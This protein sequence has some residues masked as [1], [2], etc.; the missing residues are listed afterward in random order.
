[1]NFKTYGETHQSQASHFVNYV[2][3][4]VLIPAFGAEA[5]HDGGLSIY[6][7]LDL[8]LEQKA[9]QLLYHHLYET[10]T[11]QRYSVW[12]ND[13]GPLNRT[14]NMHN[15]AVVVMNPKNGEILVMNGSA[16][17]DPS[18]FTPAMQGYY[19]A[20]ISPRPTGSS[21]KPFVYATAFEMGWYPAMIV[22]DHQ[23]YYPNGNKPYVPQNADEHF[24]SGLGYPMTIRNALASSFN[25]P[26]IDAIE[27]AGI[28]NVVHMAGRLGL[29]EVTSNPA[30][31]GPAMA[32]G[33][34]PI[35]P[36]NMT[37][38]YGTFANNGL[39]VPPV[40]ILKIIDK[41]NK[42]IYQY[43]ESHP[44]AIQVMQPGV[45]FLINSILADK[46]A[47]YHEFAPSNP[48][49]MD[50]P[51]AVKTGTTDRYRD[52]W[53]IGYTPDL[54]TGVWVGNSNNDPMYTVLGVTGAAPVWNELMTYA[55]EHYHIPPADFVVP[56]D[57]H[58]AQVSA[59]TGLA[60]QAGQ[61][62]VSDWFVDGST[63]T[64]K[65]AEA[66][67]PGATPTPTPS[68]TPNDQDKQ[69]PP[70]GKSGHHHRPKKA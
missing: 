21:F 28:N 61:P 65:G 2:V 43:D 56:P 24:H 38:A 23:T 67:P 66:P 1:M 46:R 17:T 19:N 14:K 7:T 41:Q 29:S 22:N 47:R 6:T 68:P 42:V 11:T 20:A 36:L 60:P 37:D 13:R 39:R 62:T 9:E 59:L 53:T 34:I 57:V 18:M 31:W 52:N 32:I 12:Y 49:E 30:N 25:I 16:S 5:L 33:S 27:Y 44:Q 50:Q 55:S 35:S 58:Q 15:G 64:V 45:A 40:S 3:D 70:E 69:M 4:H 63:P 26:A 48:M 51:A 8:D 54:V 10:V